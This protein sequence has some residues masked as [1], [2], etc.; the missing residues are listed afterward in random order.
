[1]RSESVRGSH[2]VTGRL[3]RL[4][5][6]ILEAGTEKCVAVV[7]RWPE[8]TARALCPID[9]TSTRVLPATTKVASPHGGLSDTPA[10]VSR[11]AACRPWAASSAAFRLLA[12][13]FPVAALL[14]FAML[15]AA[16]AQAQA[17][18]TRTL[19]SN[20]S[21]A[22]FC[23]VNTDVA[24]T[25]FT[26][27]DNAAGY[28][29]SAIRLAPSNTSSASARSGTYATV[30]HDNAGRPGTLLA[31][32]A[33]SPDDVSIQFGVPPSFHSYAAPADITL[34][35]NTTYW[36]VVNEEHASQNDRMTWGKHE[37]DTED[38]TGLSGWS[39]GDNRL[40][41]TG[42]S[43]SNATTETDSLLFSVQ[44]HAN[45]NYPKLSISDASA[46]EGSAVEFTVTLSQSLSDDVTVEYATSNGSAT[47]GSD[48]TSASAQSVTISSGQT[49]A[50]ISIAT[51]DD[52]IEEE[53]ETFTVTLSSP[54][55]NA[56]LGSPA[57]ATGT[58]LASDIVPD[59]DIAPAS[60]VEGSSVEFTVT[61][62]PAAADDVTVDY[63]TSIAAA[64]TASATD[65]TA[66]NSTTLTIAAGETSGTISIATTQDSVD[67]A[68][69]E[70][71]TLTLSNP[72]TNAELGTMSAALGTIYDDD[73][74]ALSLSVSSIDITEGETVDY[75]VALAT[76]PSEA[77]TVSIDAGASSGIVASP[78]RLS[79]TSSDWNQAQ[80]V[81][82]T[83][84]QDDDA[85]GGNPTL[86]HSASGGNYRSV[87]A[88][89]DVT[90]SDN[91][92]PDITLSVSSLSVPEDTSA[93]WTV[94]L[95]TKPTGKVTLDLAG[96]AGTDLTVTPTR[97]EFEPDVWDQPLTV[98]VSAAAASDSDDDQVAL[99]YTA[100]GGDYAGVTAKLDVLVTEM[101][102][103]PAILLSETL[104]H[105]LE[106][107]ATTKLP[108]SSYTVV[109]GSAPTGDVTVA[110]ARRAAGGGI[111]RLRVGVGSTVPT[112]SGGRSAS[113]T[114]TTDN[115]DEPQQ[116]S[117]RSNNDASADHEE[118]YS[119]KHSASGGGYDDALDVTLPVF[120]EDDD[121]AY[122]YKFSTATVTIDEGASGDYRVRLKRRPTGNVEVAIAGGGDNLA[123][124]PTSLTFT[125]D[126]WYQAQTVT[127]TAADPVTGTSGTFAL[128]HT[129][130]GGGYDSVDPGRKTVQ[131]NRSIPSIQEVTVT[132]TPLHGSDTYAQGERIAIAVTFTA[133]IAL[134]TTGGAPTLQV[135]FDSSNPVV[136]RAFAYVDMT[137]SRTL[138][139]EHTVVASDR[140]DDGLAVPDNALVL[141]GATIKGVSD[142]READIG[143]TRLTARSG[144]KVR[145][146]QTLA[147][148]LLGSLQLSYGGSEVALTPVF[149][150][151][152][153]AYT[154]T[155]TG[156]LDKATVTATGA[157]GGTASIM[158]ADASNDAGHQVALGA[159]ET[160]ITV[161][162]ARPPR[163]ESTYTLTVTRESSTVSIASVDSRVPFVLE[164]VGF[165]VT[166]TPVGAAPLEVAVTLTQSQ[167]FLTA[168]RLSQTVTIP[169]NQ[170]S[171]TLTL[172]LDD[173]RPGVDADGTL[174]ATIA[175]GVG[176]DSGSNDSST[177]NMVAA[178]PALDITLDRSSYGF[179][180]NAGTVTLNLVA[181]TAAGVPE[182][183][184]MADLRLIVRSNAGSA[185]RTQD[186]NFPQQQLV[187]FAASDFAASGDRYV[188]TKAL[189]LELIDDTDV[190]G[191]ENFEVLV[192]DS[193]VPPGVAVC[194]NGCT[195]QVT[196]ADD[197]SP[198]S[199]VM[200]VTATPDQGS[201]TVRWSAVAG[202]G[203]YKVQWKSGAESFADAATDARQATVSSG[204]TVS[205]MIPALTDGT[206]YTVR[207][208]A[209]RSGSSDGTPSDEV[210]ATPGL[211]R[212]TIED[213]SATEGAAVEFTV[214]LDRAA[215]GAVTV[216]YATTDGTATSDTMHADGAD[217]TPPASGAS[218]TIGAG[219]TSGTISIVTGDDVIDEEDETFTVTLSNP[220]SNA[221]IGTATATGTIV[222]D[223][224]ARATITG[225]AF[226][227]APSG[228]DYGVG[229]VVEVSLTFD[230]AVGVT[231]SPRLAL[232]LDGTASTNSYASY[233]AS[234]STDT[235][236]VFRRSVTESDD[237]DTDG[238]TVAANALE[239]NGGGIFNKDTTVAANIGHAAATGGSIHTRVISSIAV[240]S[241]PSVGTPAGYY[242][243]GEVVEF[244]VTFS[245]AVSVDTSSGTPALKFSA[246]DGA[247]QEAA[248]ASGSGGTTLK[249]SWTVQTDVPGTES[250]ISV[251]SNAGSDGTMLTDRGLILR[252]GSISDSTNGAV[253][254]RHG[255]F[256]TGVQ[257][258]T[259]APVLVSDASG[260]VVNG[261]AL[262]LT[263]ERASGVAEH[264][265]PGSVPDS[266]DFVVVLEGGR[267]ATVSAVEIDGAT[268]TL[269]LD[270]AL[271]HAYGGTK[272]SYTPGT[273]P[274]QDLWGNEAGHINFRAVRNDSPEP[275]L[276]VRNL[277][278]SENA[279][280][281][282]FEVALDVVSGEALTVDYATANGTAVAG[283][284][285]TGVSGTLSIG[286]NTASKT[287]SVA[288]TDDTLIES[289]ETFT[290]TLS[291]AI[292][293]S[294][295]VA[296]ATA[297]ITDDDT[298]TLTVSDASAT[299]GSP[300]EFTV[301]L[302]PPASSAVTVQYATTDV[303]AT[304]ETDYTPPASNAELTIAAGQT[305]ATISISTLADSTDEDAETF[306]L[307]L[308]SPSSNAVL[309][310]KATA[311]GTITDDETPPSL[312]LTVDKVA[313]DDT[314]NI[315]EK[316]SGFA[317]SGGTG[318]VT[319][320]GVEV[321][322]G[323]TTL[324][325]TSADVSGAARW[326]VRVPADAS[327][328]TGAS[329]T[330]TVS[331]QKSGYTSADVTR[332]VVVDLS[333]PTAPT[334]V[335]PAA[336]QVG[337][338]MAA[339]SPTDGADI[340]GYEAS[341]LP[342]GLAIAASTGVVSGTPT[343]ASASA[344]EAVVTVLD[345]AGNPAAV[346]ITF[347]AVAKGEQDLSGF[348]YSASTVTLGASAPTVT[349]PSGAET[350][351][352]YSVPASASGVCSVAASTGVLT[353]V[354]VGSCPV[355]ASAAASADWNAAASA[356]YTVTVEAASTTVSLGLAPTTVAEDAGA[357]VVTVTASLDAGV[358]D[359][360]TPVTVSVG[361][362]TATSGT[363][364]TAVD[365]FTLTIPA[366]SV[367]HTGTFTLTPSDD[368]VDEGDETV[369]VTGATTVTGLGVTGATLTIG[370]DDVRG[371]TPSVA[372]LG[373]PEGSS[374]TYT[375]VLASEPTGD[376][377]VTPSA[378]SNA[379]LS[380]APATVTFTPSNWNMA[381]TVTVSAKHDPD[382]DADSGR[383]THAVSGGDYGSVTV[384]AVE[385]TVD[386]DETAST[387]VALSVEP[388]SVDEDAG[389]TVVTVTGT[390]DHAP[391][392]SATSVTVAVGSA[393]DTATEGTDYATVGAL[394][395]TIAAGAPTG[396]AT[397]TL[398]PT[399]DAV[400]EGAETIAVSGREDD[401]TV[402]GTTLGL[403]DDETPPSLELTVDKVAGDDTVN[404][405]E[406][407]SGFAISGG[408]GTV[409][410]AGVEV[411]IGGTTLTATSADVSGAARWSVRVPADASY[412]TGASV[413]VTV[414]AQK[415][416]YTSADVTRTV[417]VDLS[418]P[419]APT[420]VAP[421]ALQ[422]GEAMAALS[423][424]DGADI[425]G[426]E[427]SGLP[428][429][430]AIAA[431]T[432]VVSGTPTAASASASEAVVTVLDAAGNPA[433]VDI[434]F[435]AVAKGEQDLSGF[436]YSASTVTLGASAP[437]VTAPSGAETVVSYSVPASA[438]GVCSVAASTGVLTLVGVGSCP[439]TASAAASADWNAAASAPYT[440]TV[441]A[442]STTVSLGLAPTTVA[443][444]AGATVVTV[445]ASLD[446]GVRDA[447]TPVTVSVGS[448]TA[449][450]G[451]D[452]T[453]VDDFT[454]TIPAG[455][456]S[457]TGTFT[458][459]PSDDAVDEG[460]ET[461]SVTGAT[462]VTGL[463]V[464]GA[465]LTIGEDDVR[466]VT[467]SVATLGVPE[468]SSATYTLVL[469]SEP[470][471]DVTVT[472]SAQSNADL[473]VAPAT[474]TFT[475]SNW[476]MA[477]TVTVSAKHDPD[478]DADSGRV[479]HAVSGGDYGSVTV[480][481]VEVT[482]DD[483]ETASTAVALSV[484]PT[485][486]D[487]DAGATV[488]TVTGTLDHAP[489]A[490]ATSV[491]VAVGSASDT[492]TEGTDYATV[493]ALSLTIA[494]RAQAFSGDQGLIG[495][496]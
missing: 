192:L 20:E 3:A 457:H 459:T 468:G 113:L 265:D 412:V 252:G 118:H 244:T 112:G 136:E 348:A 246:S 420:Y 139:F 352:S 101:A 42:S 283:S 152:T 68:T 103:T 382:G 479:T 410:G 473:S 307:T 153:R 487:E 182:P 138:N 71:F 135:N 2:R 360:A 162:A 453:A 83:A 346:D 187:R 469:A 413:T 235:V 231:G 339:L 161:K 39:I 337:E 357:T 330:V 54:S 123:T 60:A 380:V 64:D 245:E 411:E 133:D 214:K 356:P 165:T 47:G 75:T 414:S 477:R 256:T 92:V 148:A 26:T 106:A 21:L 69:P 274:I 67:E 80:T 168:S 404:I 155:I 159:D 377:T 4:A 48:Y 151:S 422:V 447:A 488:V 196:I 174:T 254:L 191:D 99:T 270:S 46:A 299:E 142:Q 160:E 181:E 261:A 150:G 74:S 449:T 120:V 25:S 126:T 448:D 255:K 432:G 492:A 372:T 427:A 221:V 183:T 115:W 111:N 344:S 444:D 95:A 306:T 223:D 289:A 345:A 409:T 419:T 338:A 156:S 292:N 363:D 107:D 282:V 324:T 1:M 144:H 328:V 8:G 61:L 129:G 484:E 417:V 30:K 458:L 393:S 496:D 225:V 452:F 271:G 290:L 84:S 434:T 480:A 359:A 130:T 333:G 14:A 90:L 167:E 279:G 296:T 280:S 281:A 94:Q 243:A 163:P 368:A 350:V 406:K 441:E 146:D 5:K 35:P 426:Y 210:S 467:P 407:A 229:D 179:L 313:G 56:V 287:V 193:G 456:V 82:L 318:T 23:G 483:D 166:R 73:A 43:W 202:A 386:D 188:A 51:I 242:G 222:N 57:S 131:V 316:A 395:L 302:N 272:V 402:T 200:G 208:I 429:G 295:G 108:V 315:A 415:S 373:V 154:A 455:S 41:K 216:E 63:E 114:F 430:L 341:G 336:L 416:G 117:V 443:E 378:Q 355:T 454:L 116:I 262:V 78:S 364:F 76:A 38:S 218:L 237:D 88:D 305:S 141:N 230:Q 70:T 362:D 478:G 185:T 203:G 394:S 119:L 391:R 31:E 177:V 207:V 251:P 326:S 147:A 423:P 471:G 91:D 387:A 125:P 55:A 29:L 371:V 304:A 342:A 267:V 312:E 180:E 329:V 482:V 286:A 77:V 450:S 375:L 240:T 28:T 389:A 206:S 408:T 249:F 175:S 102:P 189:D 314:V 239:L 85:S 87:S 460:D 481:A 32:L 17:Q 319:G 164:D 317:I 145:G 309:G 52:S 59:L 334:Y 233:S 34:E 490:S 323:G 79:F 143:G 340:A 424:T 40:N 81:S 446:A 266:G 219:Q 19:V 220:T 27:G 495:S 297:T 12:K 369:S 97:L 215:S 173:F 374:A 140:D 440:V 10:N 321:E 93:T 7:P 398:T 127:V 197:E 474:V 291:N 65:F 45:P 485:S 436:A 11:V 335:A 462:T 209:T 465:T 158:P 224:S 36:V 194:T 171:A 285:Y 72:S 132:S 149:A 13:R 437:T 104:L 300:I 445:T 347:P 198:P 62:S 199:Q 464:T 466:G 128:T 461:V 475:P 351:V 403:A 418:G 201:L 212:I 33:D 435:P 433:A 470:T 343:A 260:A 124:S 366:G 109:L 184:N 66:V 18:T 401:L 89:I 472:P 100:S 325:A 234:A 322:I 98:T 226:T 284:D 213:A 49:S 227:N 494:E 190:E 186:Y 9:E 311:T 383:V 431:S 195:A 236:L 264:L 438:S 332:T 134:D 320:A 298:P 293:A 205:H 24:A 277:T 250:A 331:A 16:P 241:S 451:T 268:L 405:A 258:D 44:G 276:S 238:V 288:I 379:D 463:G 232:Q 50:T 137:G 349:A 397:F 257:A 489:R 15:L 388:T 204:S 365:D 428:A 259:T 269:T 178:N 385:V 247:L 53:A 211:P 400:Y 6:S 493:G 301:T 439:V 157:D 176:Y 37:T 273:N 58:I 486:V 367:S 308:S 86:T 491:T 361:S 358:R 425:A 384:A 122:G 399:D 96:H 353:L 327:Y 275:V 376:V 105:V 170:A 248:Y 228:G 110:I 476:N 310:T 253:N 392:A 442:A 22:C 396:E 217:F 303:T 421:A 172:G 381:R 169:A 294:I 390:L 263:F 370:E 354:G 278:V 121:I